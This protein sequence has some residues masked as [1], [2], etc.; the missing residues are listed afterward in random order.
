MCL[1]QSI[2]WDQLLAKINEHLLNTYNEPGRV[3]NALCA[4]SCGIITI[5]I[6]V[7]G[8]DVTMSSQFSETAGAQRGEGAF[9]VQMFGD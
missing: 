5:P 1:F 9:Q 4:S 8:I 7:I 6:V 3:L 2:P